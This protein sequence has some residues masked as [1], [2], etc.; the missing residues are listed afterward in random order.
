MAEQQRI[1]NGIEMTIWRSDFRCYDGQTVCIVG[2][3]GEVF[4][5]N[6]GNRWERES[7]IWSCGDKSFCWR[8]IWT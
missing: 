6:Y 4:V 2:R 7:D 8:E 5:D 1:Q 3:D